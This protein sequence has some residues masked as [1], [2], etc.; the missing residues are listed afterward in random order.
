MGPRLVLAIGQSTVAVRL[1]VRFTVTIRWL[2]DLLRLFRE[3]TVAVM[4]TREVMIL[5]ITVS[6]TENATLHRASSEQD[7][8]L[9]LKLP[10]VGA[11]YIPVVIRLDAGSSPI[12]VKLVVTVL[13]IRVTIQRTL[14]RTP[15]PEISMEVMATVGPSRLLDMWEKT[16]A[17]VVHVKLAVNVKNMTPT[18]H[19]VEFYAEK[20]QTVKYSRKSLVNLVYMCRVSGRRPALLTTAYLPLLA[21][22]W[23]NLYKW[24][25]AQ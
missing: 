24:P 7:M 1:Q 20:V 5:M 10:M 9:P 18:L 23:V 2:E 21:G 3:D 13:T 15:A 12:M 19:M 16:V 4:I 14:L 22:R 25:L 17:I 6:A 11:S 8:E